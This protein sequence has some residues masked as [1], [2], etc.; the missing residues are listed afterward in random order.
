MIAIAILFVLVIAAALIAPG[1]VNWN[2]YKHEIEQAVADA[3]GHRLDIQGNISLA[4]LPSPHLEVADI[5]VYPPTGEEPFLKLKSAAVKVAIAPLFEGDVKVNS[6]RLIQPRLIIRISEDG[7]A[8]WMTPELEQVLGGKRN[9]EKDGAEKSGVMNSV[10]LES[11]KIENGYVLYAAAKEGK[12]TEVSN[13]DFNLKGDSLLGPFKADGSFEY[14]QQT[15]IIKGATG[16][17]DNLDSV[18]LQLDA[19][20]PGKNSA[21]KFSGVM[22][23]NGVPEVQGKLAAATT[24]IESVVNAANLT[25]AARQKP[26]NIEGMLTASSERAS[27]KNIKLVIGDSVFTGDFEAANLKGPEVNLTAGLE[28]GGPVNIDDYFVFTAG[29]TGKSKSGFVPDAVHIPVNL[30]ANITLLAPKITLMGKTFGQTQAVISKKSKNISVSIASESGPGNASVDAKST[31]VF[32]SASAVQ[33]GGMVYSDPA[34]NLS[35]RVISKNVAGLVTPFLPAELS[36]MAALRLFDE[37]DASLNA[38]IEPRAI[39]LTD[40]V[41]KLD[42]TVYGISGSYKPSS[43]QGAK[44]DIKLQL[45]ADTLDLNKILG[46]LEQNAPPVPAAT[47]KA[48]KKFDLGAEVRKLSL[49]VNMEFDLGAQKI[50]YEDLQIGGVRVQ[51][52][53]IGDTFTLTNASVADFFKGK[54]AASGKIGDTQRLQGIDITFSGNAQNMEAIIEAL[55]IDAKALPRPFGSLVFSANIAGGAQALDFKANVSAFKGQVDALGQL[56]DMLVAPKVNN[57][58]AAIKHPNFVEAVRLADQKFKGTPGMERPLDLYAEVRREGNVYDLAGL[59]ANL[60]PMPV[61]GDVKIDMSGEVPLVKGGLRFGSVPL[62]DFLKTGSGGKAQGSPAG[63]GGAAAGDDVRWSRNAINTDWMHK[64]ALDLKLEA[65][66][67]SYDKWLFNSPAMTIRLASGALNVSDFR[68]GLFGGT[69]AASGEMRSAKDPRAPVQIGA[70]ADLKGVMVESFVQAL[71]GSQVLKASGVAD[72]NTE[73]QASGISPAALVFNLSGK[74]VLNGQ[75]F[76]LEGVDFTRFAEAL[77]DETKPGET[78]SGLWKGATKGGQTK[79][80]S[81][82]GA[83]TIKEGVAFIN[84]LVLDGPEVLV[85]SKGELSLPRWTI[86]LDNEITIKNKPDIPKFNVLIQGPL[87]N[88]GQTFGQGLLEDYLKR[89]ISRK[90][91]EKLGGDVG[92]EFGDALGKALGIPGAGKQV[93]PQPEPQP[94]SETQPQEQ[95]N[96]R[97]QELRPEDVLQ[98]VLKELIR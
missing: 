54:F 17:I 24:R 70:K 9:E 87:D 63:G 13:I 75:N 36:Q 46:R 51:G 84:P 76:V 41:V 92:G 69:I 12:S 55:K 73:M 96:Q 68:S 16:R 28:A 45:A 20:F 18:A 78:V 21:A 88:P 89:K 74:G 22:D 80:D 61:M 59:K 90:I 6:I 11:V 10:S 44:D 65:N 71:T 57:L 62:S 43:A 5:A 97:P 33:G 29:S 40:S 38:T 56:T 1:F 4:V 14:Q 48:P 32:S 31:L 49:P 39:R 23:M 95:Q 77:S 94:P 52:S 19:T 85:N 47:G 26:V 98:G 66:S 91:G 82:T 64:V 35:M 53:S 15:I 34:V 67:L 60:G 42:Q 79:F 27:L 8:N 25:K 83:Y 81:V 37:M 93:K 72:L 30:D 7:K 2:K 50:L 58:T 86:K 3:T